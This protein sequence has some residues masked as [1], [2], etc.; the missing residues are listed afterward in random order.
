MSNKSARPKKKI[1]SAPPMNPSL[2]RQGSVENKD[3]IK[4]SFFSFM[5]FHNLFFSDS[6]IKFL[7]IFFITT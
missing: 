6:E 1:L 5:L 4:K 7:L 3:I 2:F